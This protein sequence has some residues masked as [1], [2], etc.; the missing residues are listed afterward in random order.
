MKK[1]LT[2]ILLAL[3][4]IFGVEN[5]NTTQANVAVGF[6]LFFDALSPYGNWVSVPR[7]GNVWYPTAVGPHWKPYTDGRWIW[8]D[9][10]WT[11][12]SYEPWGWAPYHYGRWIFLD[13]YGW[14]WIP[15][16]V[17]A[18]AWVTWYT[19]PGYIG[20]AP[21][22]P[23]NDF[24]LQIGIGQPAGYNY[25]IQPSPPKPHYARPRAARRTSSPCGRRQSANH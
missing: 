8:S 12:A 9:Y 14:V 18:P 7:Y 16:T 21:L 19:S 5:N 4:I 2:I 1:K 6:N 25:Y 15:G 17:W 3:A 24:F 13:Y 11:W 10:G 23:D 22:A 20:W